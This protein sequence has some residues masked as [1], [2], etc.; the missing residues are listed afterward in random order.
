MLK[1]SEEPLQVPISLLSCVETKVANFRPHHR[2][3]AERREPCGPDTK[4]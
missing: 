3:V 1:V 4:R 2:F